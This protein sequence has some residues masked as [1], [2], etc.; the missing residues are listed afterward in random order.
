MA[1]VLVA[2]VAVADFVFQVGEMPREAVKYRASDAV[3]TGGGCAANAAVAIA[4]DGG[5]VLLA[6]RLGDDPVGRMIVADLETEGVDTKLCHISPEGKSSFSSVY[7]DTAGERQIMNFRGS[8]LAADAS[9]LNDVPPVDAVLVDNRWTDIACRGIEIAREQGVPCI[10]D[11]EAPIEGDPFT[12]ATHVAFARRGLESFTGVHDPHEALMEAQTRLGCWVCVTD[13][14]EGSLYAT[15]DG[16]TGH[17]PAYAVETRDTLGAGDV[18]HGVFALELAGGADEIVAI[19]R[20]SAAAAIKCTRFGGRDGT[21]T[22]TETDR[23]LKE[24]A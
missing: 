24:R 7:V 3:V 21:P 8:G 15:R 17:V 18:W 11:G 10:V 9:W 19:R 12:G 23:F 22:K 2:G 6:A 13:G 1:R 16:M 5:E 20:A 4:R 14:A